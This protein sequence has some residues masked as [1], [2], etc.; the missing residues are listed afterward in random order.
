[1]SCLSNEEAFAPLTAQKARTVP[2]ALRVRVA[3]C[4]SIAYT[5]S[6]PAHRYSQTSKDPHE[7][8]L[9]THYQSV[10]TSNMCF[11]STLVAFPNLMVLHSTGLHLAVYDQV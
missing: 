5:H 7:E 6:P 3:F 4:A 1:M 10:R 2:S 8:Q 9:P 11:V